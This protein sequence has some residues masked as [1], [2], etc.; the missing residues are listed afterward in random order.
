MGIT[1]AIDGHSSCGKS[2]LARALASALGYIYVDSGA[3]YRAVTLHFLRGDIALDDATAV[4]AELDT[5]ELDF[6]TEGGCQFIRL[7]GEVLTDELRAMPVNRWVSP[8]ATLSAVRAFL[9]AKQRLLGAR[10]SIVMD[11][12]DIGTV[13]FPDAALKLFVTAS[14]AVRVKRRHTELFAQGKTVTAEAVERNLRER[15]HIDST[16]EDSPLRQAADA[17]LL[18]NTNLDRA[19]Q[20][21]MILALAKLRS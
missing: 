9:V 21:A 5:L 8:V 10:G 14:E 12:R 2:T 18:D 19:E 6:V 11:G 16:R 7:N 4:A 1:I 13:V 20:L 3:M 17:V 15:D